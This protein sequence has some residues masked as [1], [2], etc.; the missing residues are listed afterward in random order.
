[1]PERPVV[2]LISRHPKHSEIGS[3]GTGV[4]VRHFI[5]SQAFGKQF[6][7]TSATVVFEVLKSYITWQKK[8]PVGEA[9]VSLIDDN[10]QRRSFRFSSFSN[11]H[12]VLTF[13][14]LSE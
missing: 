7:R 9:D 3:Q 5:Y 4:P 8:G 11:S 12:D 10:G 6:S 14:F 1:M 2:G 13:G